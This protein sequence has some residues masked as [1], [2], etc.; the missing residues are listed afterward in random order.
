MAVTGGAIAMTYRFTPST[1]A[2]EHRPSHVGSI[3]HRCGL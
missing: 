1:V 2:A 3:A